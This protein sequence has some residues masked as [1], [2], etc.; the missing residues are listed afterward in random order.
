EVAPGVTIAPNVA[1]IAANL[2]YFC[3][4]N[5]LI[6]QNDPTG[7]VLLNP[8]IAQ[9]V[10]AVQQ[11]LGPRKV[12]MNMDQYTKLDTWGVIDTFTFELSDTLTLRN[13]LS[14]QRM[15]QDY[16]WDLDGS[17]LPILS[18]M[19]SVVEPGNPFGEVGAQASV[20]DSSLL[21]EE[22]QFQGNTLD[23]R[24]QFVFGGYYSNSKPEGLEAT[25]SFNAANLNLSGF[26]HIEN[27]SVAAY[28]QSTLNL[29]AFTPSLEKL[30]FTAGIRYTDDRITGSRYATNC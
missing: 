28:S 1:T 11:Q 26:R 18:H 17:I 23:G 10:L 25:G 19:L 13:I 9:Q 12:A 4:Q 29:G 27:R 5:P 20:T 16:V 22:L 7:M 15:E 21:T 2:A 8:A 30:S 6:C 14:Y 3:P 24:L